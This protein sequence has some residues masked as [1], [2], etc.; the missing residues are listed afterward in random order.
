MPGGHQEPGL[1]LARNTE[2]SQIWTMV[3]RWKRGQPSTVL[4]R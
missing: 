2:R 1:P 4:K 3:E